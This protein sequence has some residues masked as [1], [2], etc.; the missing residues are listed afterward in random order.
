MTNQQLYG[1]DYEIPQGKLVDFY[2]DDMR[3]ILIRL[4]PKLD[5]DEIEE[6]MNWAVATSYA[7]GKRT[8]GH[9]VK[10]HNNNTNQV[11]EMDFLSLS[12]ELLEKKPIITTQGVLFKRHD[13][14]SV[15]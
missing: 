2:K 5:L 14:G 13:S 6:A 8:F 3:E 1:L 12:N 10:V 4:C 7:N 11:A 9:E 15:R